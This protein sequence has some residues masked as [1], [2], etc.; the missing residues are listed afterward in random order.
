LIRRQT[1]I[2]TTTT[3]EIEIE[4]ELIFGEKIVT[5]QVTIIV[6][7]NKKIH[8]TSSMVNLLISEAL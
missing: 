3:T 4:I 1:T 7:M 6:I 8:R 5:M 2:T